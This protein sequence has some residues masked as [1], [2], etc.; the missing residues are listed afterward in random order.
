MKY[1]RRQYLINPGFQLK[2][3]FLITLAMFTFNMAF[4]LFMITMIDAAMGHRLIIK[5][6]VAVEALQEARS[7]FILYMVL[8]EVLFILMTF[9]L[10]LFHSH[11]IAGPLYKLRIS[12]AALK[13]GVLDRHISFRSKDNFPEL[14]EEFN[15]MSDAIF[16]RRRK[17]L[18]AIHSLIPKMEELHTGLSGRQK[19]VAA[20]ALKSLQNLS[21]GVHS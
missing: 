8:L 19:E 20:E 11:K 9:V 17:D 5:N 12:M 16:A 10:A 4:P 2:F 18:E 7:E 6:P 1:N 15:E 13:Q 3:S 21:R 14:A